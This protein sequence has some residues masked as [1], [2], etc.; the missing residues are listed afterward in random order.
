MTH[1]VTVYTHDNTEP[2][3]IFS[4]NIKNS[5]KISKKKLT[6]H[7]WDFLKCENNTNCLTF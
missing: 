5:R 2:I 3:E 6:L 4:K 1:Q 7:D